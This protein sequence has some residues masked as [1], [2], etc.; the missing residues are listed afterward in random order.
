MQMDP[1]QVARPSKEIVTL[2]NNNFVLD[3]MKFSEL[4]VQVCKSVR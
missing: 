4:T 3:N 2:F 1:L